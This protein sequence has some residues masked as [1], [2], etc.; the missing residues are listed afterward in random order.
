MVS[1]GSI[2]HGAPANRLHLNAGG[3][4]APIPRS[5]NPRHDHEW[6]VARKFR[7]PEGKILIPGRLY[8]NA[9]ESKP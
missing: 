7:V 5:A 2:T 1:V 4:N 6:R 8:P 9:C 3:E